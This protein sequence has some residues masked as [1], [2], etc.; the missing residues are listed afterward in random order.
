ME[1]A[2][3][4]LPVVGDP[5][6]GSE[7]EKSAHIHEA[8]DASLA[9]ELRMHAIAHMSQDVIFWP[10]DLLCQLLTRDRIVA[11]L[12][13]EGSHA[14]NGSKIDYY[15]DMIGPV[16][17]STADIPTDGD[18]CRP[19]LEP[20]RW[21][22][23]LAILVLLDK[24]DSVKEFI[25]NDVSDNDLPLR[26][27]PGETLRDSFCLFKH[28]GDTEPPACFR[29]W[30]LSEMEYFYD[31]QWRVHVPFF[32]FQRGE[33]VMHYDL[34]SRTIFPWR[35][36]SMSDD[37]EPYSGGFGTVRRVEMYPSSHQFSAAFMGVSIIPCPSPK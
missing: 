32:E 28:D 16:Y 33:H 10:F 2:S 17:K 13:T 3:S 37:R 1:P 11:A 19:T 26:R 12:R 14:I 5:K 31:A 6:S 27:G 15:V 34:P 36:E 8:H 24:L 35:S 4:V 23:I 25:D 30:R 29:Q 7:P 22:K 20:K 21:L 9:L 18:P